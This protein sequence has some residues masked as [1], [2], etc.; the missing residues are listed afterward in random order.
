MAIAEQAALLICLDVACG[1]WAAIASWQRQFQ[2]HRTRRLAGQRWRRASAALVAAAFFI[3]TSRWPLRRL[4]RDPA[5][6]GSGLVDELSCALCA[7][8]LVR[9]Q[10][11]A[12]GPAGVA[13]A[14]L[15]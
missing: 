1:L 9:L 14:L 11:R 12:A 4:L 3:H 8:L 6:T 2:Q 10:A 13:R 5:R 15:T 7:L